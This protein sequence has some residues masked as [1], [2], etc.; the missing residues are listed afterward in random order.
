MGTIKINDTTYGA[1]IAS[2]IDFNNEVS[3]L[4]A[5]NVQEAINELAYSIKSGESDTMAREVLASTLTQLG[6]PTSSDASFVTI[7]EN[8]ILL[9]DLKY[10]EGEEDGTA[11]AMIG[12]ATTD[13]VLSGKIFTNKNDAGLT[14]TMTNNGA[15]SSSVNCGASYTIPKGYHNGSGKVTGNTLESQTSANAT[16]A[17]I[18]KGKTAYVNG[19]KITGTH[20][21]NPM[22]ERGTLS[23]SLG[24]AVS[25][26][27]VAYFTKP[28]TAK[29]TV[30]IIVT[31]GEHISASLGT[32]TTSSA[33]F[34]MSHSKGNDTHTGTIYW[35]AYGN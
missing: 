3:E 9:A 7:N 35:I 21:D 8:I 33:Q 13:D 19:S 15:V 12:D 34:T 2:E 18:L 11:A 5:T 28:F 25:A 23:K 29:P 26:T 32:V 1:S 4:E 6:V 24:G 30:Q 22:F 16:E 20:V 17:D 10:E 27:L 31:T 14:G